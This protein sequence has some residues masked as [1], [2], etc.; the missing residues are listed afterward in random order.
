MIADARK[1]LRSLRGRCK[2]EGQRLQGHEG[3]KYAGNGSAEGRGG[4]GGCVTEPRRSEGLCAG[5][6]VGVAAV[7]GLTARGCWT[8]VTG[9]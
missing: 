2:R 7:K 6:A 5:M 8:A 9:R 3:V 1:H 4:E